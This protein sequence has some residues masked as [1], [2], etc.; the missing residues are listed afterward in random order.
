MTRSEAI[1]VIVERLHRAG[2]SR[3]TEDNVLTEYASPATVMIDNTLRVLSD[4]QIQPYSRPMIDTLSDLR[5][6]ISGLCS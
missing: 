6:E 1:K 3:A 2:F 4:N 5:R